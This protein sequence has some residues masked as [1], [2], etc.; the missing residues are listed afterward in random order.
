MFMS[1]NVSE[2]D[3]RTAKT[4]LDAGEAVMI[5]IRENEEWNQE[6]VPGVDLLPLSAF[7]PAQLPAEKLGK[8]LILC[9]SGRRAEMLAQA[10]SAQGFHK[11]PVVVAGGILAWRAEGLPVEEGTPKAPHFSVIQGGKAVA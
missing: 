6:R 3:V 5:D 7:N 1:P 10:L 2:V 8:L 4:W 9:R 11:S